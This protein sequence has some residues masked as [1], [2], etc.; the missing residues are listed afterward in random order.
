MSGEQRPASARE[1]DSRTDKIP[2]LRKATELSREEIEDPRG[3]VGPSLEAVAA[4]LEVSERALRRRLG[5]LE[6]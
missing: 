3:R 4:E 5:E 1:V 6:S 2:S